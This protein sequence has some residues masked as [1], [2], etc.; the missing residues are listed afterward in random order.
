MNNSL[1]RLIDGMVA[2]LRQEVIPHVSGEFAR[3]QAFGVIYMLNSI[4]LRADWSAGFMA[5]QLAAQQELAKQLVALDVDAEL[6]PALAPVPQVDMRAL[7]Q[8]RNDNDRK[9]CDL[10]DWLEAQRATL[11]PQ[12]HAAIDAA[13]AQYM[14]RQL[15]WEIS[16]SAK[17]M[18]AEMSSGT[19]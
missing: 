11:D 16:T 8:Q 17:P 18:F 2:T 14:H 15:K 5:E 13:V 12:R 3:G 19:E 1:N 10:L 4:R 9:V 7:E 6:R